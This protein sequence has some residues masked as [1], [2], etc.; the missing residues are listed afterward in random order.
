MKIYVH[1][2][3]G[4]EDMRYTFKVPRTNHTYTF[5][6]SIN[7]SNGAI[8]GDIQRI[9]AYDDADY[10][11][12]KLSNNGQVKFI[13]NGKVVDKMQLWAYDDE[14]YESI[15]D[16]FSDIISTVADDLDQYNDEIEPRMMYD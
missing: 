11:W 14:D 2:N 1:C 15:D 4:L 9:A 13:H 6:G 10:Y 16:Y 7:K 3:S 5:K 12:A 8:W